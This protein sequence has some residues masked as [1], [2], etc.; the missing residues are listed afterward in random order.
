MKQR[1]YN[2]KPE[3]KLSQKI[4]SKNYLKISTNKLRIKIYG[5]EYRIKN[6]DEERARISKWM[7]KNREKLNETDRIRWKNDKNFNIK[8]K[9]KYRLWFVIN[10]YNSDGKIMNAESY[11]V[12]YMAIIEHLKPFPKDLSKYHIDHIRPLCSFDLTDTEQVKEAFAPENHQW[13][14]I[15]QNLKKGGKWDGS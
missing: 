1:E 12:N 13:L 15:K 7:S 3:I 11:G 9:L 10:K 2:S 4:Y 6:K 14:T 8:R 5:R